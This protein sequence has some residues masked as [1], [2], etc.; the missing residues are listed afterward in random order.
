MYCHCGQ[1]IH[2]KRLKLGYNT[3]IECST[4]V[5][6]KSVD[7]TYHKTGNTIEVLPADVADEI[8]KKSQRRGFGIMKGMQPSGSSSYNPK[9]IKHGASNIYIGATEIV[10]NEIGKE[11][12]E[13]YDILGMNDSNKF[14]N[15]KFQ[16]NII[17]LSQKNKLLKIINLI[18]YNEKC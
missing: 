11:M 8:N 4:E 13:I 18:N 16:Q 6:V 10:F 9:N 7:I 1:S 5:Q 3:C 12:I 17:S 2:S 15:L 14:I